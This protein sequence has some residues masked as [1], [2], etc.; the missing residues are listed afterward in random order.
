M[1]YNG[2]GNLI[3]DGNLAP[4]TTYQGSNVNFNNWN[5]DLNY[6]WQFAPGSQLIAFYRNSIF[7]AGN[8]A[9]QTFFEN[10]DNLFNES[11]RHTVS[12]QLVYFIDY[13]KLRNI[14]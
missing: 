6:F 13:N 9:N 4:N 12:I 3:A 14:F 2:Y 1:N 11:Q 10:L 7:N 5:L 8:N